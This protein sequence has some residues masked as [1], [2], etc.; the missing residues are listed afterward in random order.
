MR[1]VQTYFLEKTWECMKCNNVFKADGE[2]DTDNEDKYPT[3]IKNGN[4][5]CT[6]C[7]SMETEEA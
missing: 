5:F 3:L 7:G 6:H 2:Y 4:P 1:T